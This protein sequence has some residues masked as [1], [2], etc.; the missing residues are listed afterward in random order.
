MESP[1]DAEEAA[2]L[3]LRDTLTDVIFTSAQPYEALPGYIGMQDEKTPLPVWKQRLLA[4]ERLDPAWTDVLSALDLPET[5]PD[6]ALDMMLRQLCAYFLYRHLPAALDDGDV[7][8][9]VAFA[10]L[11]CRLLG[12]LAAH[13]PEGLGELARMY[14]AEIEYSD[15]NLG[16]L[17]DYLA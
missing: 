6:P 12:H 3:A 5:A 8:S 13:R 1:S 10:C 9:R 4:L 16:A 17:L 14:S 11:S 7:A 15:E 2:L